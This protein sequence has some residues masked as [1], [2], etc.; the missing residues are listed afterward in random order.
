MPWGLSPAKPGFEGLFLCWR[1]PRRPRSPWKDGPIPWHWGFSP[2]S[3]F[4]PSGHA[5]GKRR[6][7][8]AGTIVASPYASRV[9]IGFSLKCLR[10]RATRPSTSSSA[11][12]SRPGAEAVHCCGGEA[13]P[14]LSIV[15][16][17]ANTDGFPHSRCFRC[18][19]GGRQGRQDA[20]A[21]GRAP[22]PGAPRSTRDN[23]CCSAGPGFLSGPRPLR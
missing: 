5:S 17:C 4:G 7:P 15:L 8:T 22:Y 10:W 18:A 1:W 12:A 21:R 16:L 11:G 14:N 2:G 6:V 9:V 3:C 20:G 13:C 23:P 19:S